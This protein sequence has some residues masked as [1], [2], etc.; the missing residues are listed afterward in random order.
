M[1]TWTEWR[2]SVRSLTNEH[3]DIELESLRA[4]C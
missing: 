1:T 3:I 2:Y 4:V